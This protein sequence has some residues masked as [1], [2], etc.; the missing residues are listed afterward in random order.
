MMRIDLARLSE[1]RPMLLSVSWDAKGR[2]LDAPGIRFEEPV[3]IAV[4]AKR[5]SGLAVAQVDV[6]SKATMTCARCLCDFAV[7]I[8][9]SFKL[10]YAL[11]ISE[12]VVELDDDIRQE[13][14]L[15]YPQKVLCREDCRGICPR[16]GV[17]LNKERCKCQ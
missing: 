16:C 14:I 4:S 6:R 10:A 2:E 13:L 8:E 1:E 7:K 3:K 12:P 9:R 11:D 15:T 5:D 17:D